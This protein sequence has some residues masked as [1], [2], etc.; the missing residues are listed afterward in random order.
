MA[1]GFALA[2]LALAAGSSVALA[3]LVYALSGAMILV[4]PIGRLALAEVA[5]VAARPRGAH[6]RRRPRVA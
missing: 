4:G 1:G 5:E 2:M 6:S 3:F